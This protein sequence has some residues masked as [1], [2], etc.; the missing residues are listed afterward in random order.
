MAII[1][2]YTSEDFG[3]SSTNA[4]TKISSFYVNNVS[5]LDKK[6]VIFTET[7]VTKDSRLASKKTIGTNDFVLPLDVDGNFTF[8]DMY[9]FIKTQLQFPNAVDD[10]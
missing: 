6:V 1:S 3:L 8:A 2:E 9:N 5:E 7:W 4:Y 10:I